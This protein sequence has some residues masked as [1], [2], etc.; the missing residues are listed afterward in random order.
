MILPVW[1]LPAL[2]AVLL[3]PS[4]ALA[5][6]ADEGSGRRGAG[7]VAV[8]KL[9]RAGATIYCGGRRKQLVA[10]TFDDGPTRYS[11]QIVAELRRFKARATFFLLGSRLVYYPGALRDEAKVGTIGDHT[12]THP[13]LRTLDAAGLREQIGRTRAAEIGRTGRRILLFRPPYGMRTRA[14]DAYV[15]GLG[16]LQVLWDVADSG[17]GIRPGSIV[18]LHD[19]RP[20]TLTLLR[21]ILRSLRARHLRAVTVPELLAND[22]PRL[23]RDA[24]GLLRSSCY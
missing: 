16:M 4:N 15:R 1:R 24:N 11:R 14:A 22:P 6:V 21:G 8:E 5:V 17:A 9:A 13:Y 20:E 18:V 12:W 10:L 2:V 19:T 23:F 7:E 3:L